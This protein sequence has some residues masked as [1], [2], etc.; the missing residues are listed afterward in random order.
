MG[1]KPSCWK[2][3]RSSFGVANLNAGFYHCVEEDVVV[4]FWRVDLNG[5]FVAMVIVATDVAG[6]GF[7]EVGEAV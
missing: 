7:F 4:W 3:L 5:A 1:P 6:L 2:P